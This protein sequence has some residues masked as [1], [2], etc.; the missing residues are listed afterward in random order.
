MAMIFQNVAMVAS[1]PHFFFQ[2]LY[3]YIVTEPI[4]PMVFGYCHTRS[5]SSQ[6]FNQDS[7]FFHVESNEMHLQPRDELCSPF[8]L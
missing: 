3:I 4:A 5:L 2:L 7:Y 1:P 6:Y 8:V